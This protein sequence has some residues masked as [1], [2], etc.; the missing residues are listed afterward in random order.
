[1]VA[2]DSQ[3]SRKKENGVRIEVDPERCAASGLCVLTVPEV[4]EQSDED[5]KVMLLTP[6]PASDQAARVRAAVSRCPTGA[7]TLAEP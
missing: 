2:V 5:G 1:V 3:P 4:F 7:I 6:G